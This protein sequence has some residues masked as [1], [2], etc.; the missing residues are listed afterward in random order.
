MG[1]GE[2]GVETQRKREG[3]VGRKRER[4]RKKGREREFDKFDEFRH[5]L[6]Y[7]VR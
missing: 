3:G 5:V 1:G 7:F 4:G 6:F 2:E